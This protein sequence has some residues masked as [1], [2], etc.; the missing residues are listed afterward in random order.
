MTLVQISRRPPSV[1]SA[2]GRASTTTGNETQAAGDTDGTQSTTSTRTVRALVPAQAGLL[3][4]DGPAPAPAPAPEPVGH[5]AHAIHI[6]PHLSHTT[7]TVHFWDPGPRQPRPGQVKVRQTTQGTV[8][9]CEVPECPRAYGRLEWYP[10]S[11]CLSWCTP[12][13]DPPLTNFLP[14]WP[15]TLLGAS[16]WSTSSLATPPLPR[17]PPSEVSISIRTRPPAVKWYG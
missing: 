7:V 12:S 16:W 17:S 13:V 5:E 8:S 15:R 11:G 1:I 9:Q 6:P 10:L 14:G 3:L 2:R 4:L